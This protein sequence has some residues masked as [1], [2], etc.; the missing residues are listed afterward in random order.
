MPSTI[1]KVTLAVLFL[2]CLLASAEAIT[3]DSLKIFSWNMGSDYCRYGNCH[4]Y[5]KE[6]VDKVISLGDQ[7]DILC[8]Q[9]FPKFDKVQQSAAADKL[10]NDFVLKYKYSIFRKE[11]TNLAILSKFP[12]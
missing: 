2:A 10:I 5:V 4:S 8:L 3:Y 7:Y 11:G 12:I 6:A 1:Y 9:E